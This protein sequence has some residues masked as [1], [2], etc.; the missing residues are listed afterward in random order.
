MIFMAGLVLIVIVVVAMVFVVTFLKKQ[1]K[2]D[3]KNNQEQFLQLAR[4]QFELEQNKAA[5]EFQLNKQAPHGDSKPFG[6][7]GGRPHS[8]VAQTSI[9]QC[10]SHRIQFLPFH[11]SVR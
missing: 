8:V 3:L 10:D 1:L 11:G 4:Q 7:E 9:R 2:E 5:S 6:A